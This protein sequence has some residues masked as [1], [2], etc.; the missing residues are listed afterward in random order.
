MSSTSHSKDN[1]NSDQTLP[2]YVYA[3]LNPDIYTFEVNQIQ[4]IQTH[5]SYVFL[6]GDRVYKTKKPVDF[7]FINQ[8]DLD[9]RHNNCIREVDL[10]R[11]LAPDVYINIVMIAQS[12]S[13]EYK[14][15]NANIPEN[16][17][18]IEYAVEMQLLPSKAILANIL[19]NNV[20]PEQFPQ[21]FAELILDFHS[22]NSLQES[23]TEFAGASAVQI[24]WD[25]ER[26]EASKFI[27][28]TWNA[29][30]AKDFSLT[31]TKL[32]EQDTDLLNDRAL[33]G[34]IVE[35]HGD[36]HSMHIYLLE[37]KIIIVDC[38]EFN[39]WFHFRILDKG[40]D[41]AFTAMDLEARGFPEVGDEIVG[42]YIAA[43]G[44]ETLPILQPLHRAFR[45]FVRGKVESIESNQIGIPREQKLEKKESAATYFT[46]ASKIIHER[47]DS[48][49]ILICGLS[50]TGKSTIGS[51]LSARIGAAYLSSDIIR[52]KIAGIPLHNKISKQQ[53]NEIY[54]TKMSQQTYTK[55]RES[56]EQYIQKGYS[57]VLD[58][59]HHNMLDR[60]KVLDIAKKYNYETLIIDLQISETEALS[61]IASRNFDPLAVSDAT[62][63]VYLKQ[64]EQ[65]TPISEKEGPKMVVKTN[66]S[67]QT[68]VKRIMHKISSPTHK[69]LS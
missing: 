47:T 63:E 1:S 14:I 22:K 49:L 26:Q 58:A 21:K 60:K 57:V 48:F 40:Y 7:G 35:G 4:L 28:S 69:K 23:T 29:N 54:T 67:P 3:L 24:W 44:D 6:A 38:I 51:Q 62:S 25:R 9:Q 43:S 34:H 15:F 16:F 41:I 12:Q 18:L 36:L 27:G 31:I 30:D 55:M 2:D 50:G 52:K 8:L 13:G 37:Q 66:E 53:S 59:T 10:N 20:M 19:A 42:R 56:A 32:L 11:R 46:L 61:R 5:I 39:D 65:F 68:I 33:G 45:A 64:V 17:V